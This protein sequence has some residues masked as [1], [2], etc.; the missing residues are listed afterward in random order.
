[1]KQCHLFPSRAESKTTAIGLNKTHSLI[2]Q[3]LG[4]FRFIPENHLPYHNEKS[5]NVN[6]KRSLTEANSEMTLRWNPQ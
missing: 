1:M 3:Y 4:M 6:K 2:I 5:Q